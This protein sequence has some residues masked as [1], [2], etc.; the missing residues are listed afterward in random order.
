MMNI[1]VEISLDALAKMIA[2]DKGIAGKETAGLLLGKEEGGVIKVI[3]IESGEQEATSVH[4]QLTDD[5]LVN[6]VSKIAE[7]NDDLAIVGWWHT[8]P[9]LSAFMSPTDVKTQSLYQAMF[10]K[11][12]AIVLDPLQY[13]K[14]WDIRDLDLKVFRVKN[15][16]YYEVPFRIEGPLQILG[17]KVREYEGIEVKARPELTQTVSTKKYEK[18]IVPKP[19]L[20]QI[21]E[22]EKLIDTFEGNQNEIQLLRAYVLGLKA[23]SNDTEEIETDENTAKSLNFFTAEI[24]NL[25]KLLEEHYLRTIIAKDNII[26]GFWL[27]MSLLISGVLI[28]LISIIF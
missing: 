8:H 21:L 28:G 23:L 27:F 15:G 7:R 10:D 25:E 3:D 5:A 4:V 1:E 12:I 26:S 14:T 11:A 13:Q 9:G 24:R 18:Y 2:F 17:D 22:I 16:S 6:I 19:S 20:E